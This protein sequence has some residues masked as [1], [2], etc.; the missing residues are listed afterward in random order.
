MDGPRTPGQQPQNDAQ[1]GAQ[2]MLMLLEA[3]AFAPSVR[4]VFRYFKLKC[5]GSGSTSI[6]LRPLGREGF[7]RRVIC[8]LCVFGQ[9]VKD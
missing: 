8:V 1:P 4:P 3:I 2:P 7:G 5:S 9:L 6:R